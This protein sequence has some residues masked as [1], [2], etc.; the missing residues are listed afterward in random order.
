MNALKAG[1]RQMALVAP[2]A[3]AL[4]WPVPA[5]ADVEPPNAPPPD[6]VTLEVTANGS[7]CKPGGTVQT[8][9]DRDNNGFGAYFDELFAMTGDGAGPTAARR[10]C[11]FNLRV[12]GVPDGYRYAVA[13]AD[14]SGYKYLQ[15]GATG[16]Q[17]TNFYFQGMSQTE[18]R[19]H[20]FT[21]PAHGFWEVHDRGP[22]VWSP[23]RGPQRNANINMELR[24][25]T[26]AAVP[27]PL[28]FISMTSWEDRALA[29]FRLAWRTC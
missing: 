11:Q 20:R 18:Y 14:Y 3:V 12:N 15:P 22:T 2:V 13:D 21:G 27:T 19:E 4:L 1:I 23:C 26:G 5:Y 6:G 25:S 17:R 29:H 24:V 9:V 10:N 7:G 28:N 8:H 16:L